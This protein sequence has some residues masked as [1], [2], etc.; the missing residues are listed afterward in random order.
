MP[1]TWEVFAVLL[2]AGLSLHA[3]DAASTPSK[4]AVAPSSP[5]ENSATAQPP[6]AAQYPTE[7]T[8]VE[9]LYR[10]R[11]KYPKDA[12]RT[13]IQG[14]VVLNTVITKDGSVQNIKLTCGDP[15]LVNAAMDAVRQWRYKPYQLN[16][17]PVEAP[18]TITVNFS[19]SNLGNEKID[20]CNRLSGPLTAKSVDPAANTEEGEVLKPGNGV[21]P[22]HAIY[23]PEPEYSK[24]ARKAKLQGT[25]VLSIIINANGEVHE[26]TVEKSLGLG[27][28]EKAIEA[29][30]QWRFEPAMKD[31]KPVAVRVHVQTSFHLY[32]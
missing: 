32:R 23:M 16:G 12:R 27:L 19:L 5:A 3:Q 22:P 15:L 25:V 21:I 18:T 13:K 17:E 24:K 11:P 8:P 9:L 1:K 6:T 29:V 2:I 14:Q 4:P 7:I 30:R 31:G 10:V 28:D 20:D 26:I